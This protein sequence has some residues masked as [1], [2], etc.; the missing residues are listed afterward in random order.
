M[1][2]RKALVL[3]LSA[4]LGGAGVAIAVS[5]DAQAYEVFAQATAAGELAVVAWG[6]LLAVAGVALALAHPMHVRSVQQWALPGRAL[7]WTGCLAGLLFTSL[8]VAFGYAALVYGL[9]VLS[10]R[11]AVFLPAATASF[12]VGSWGRS[13][14][15]LRNTRCR[16]RLT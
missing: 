10:T 8:V 3:L 9:P 15:H 14:A 4:Q 11:L 7:F 1:S 13:P 6:A 16:A 12:L 5:P 2:G